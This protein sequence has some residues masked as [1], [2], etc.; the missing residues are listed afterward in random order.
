MLA[1]PCVTDTD[2]R[3][4]INGGRCIATMREE[5]GCRRA[6]RRMRDARLA[7]SSGVAA[8]I[9][10]AFDDLLGEVNQHAFGPVILQFVKRPQQAQFEQRLQR[11]GILRRMTS[12]RCGF[13]VV[14]GRGTDR[15]KRRARRPPASGGWRRCRSIRCVVRGL[16]RRGA[17]HFGKIGLR[18]PDRKPSRLHQPVD[19]SVGGCCSL[20]R[21]ACA[22]SRL[23]TAILS[24][25]RR[26][27]SPA[28]R[29]CRISADRWDG[30]TR[31]GTRDICGRRRIGWSSRSVV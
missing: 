28:A 15:E 19:L 3:G 12:G 30:R 14:H 24:R 26:T 8:A 17:E 7:A 13:A 18:K 2:F 6:R 1:R 20:L 27:N 21:S 5:T 23:A 29:P 4:V 22:I 9:G 10:L 16:L 11:A 31:R 25:I